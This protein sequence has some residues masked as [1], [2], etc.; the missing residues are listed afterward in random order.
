[1]E[2]PVLPIVGYS[3]PTALHGVGIVLLY[4]AKGKL[5]NQKMITLN[6]A[7]AEL[8]YCLSRAIIYTLYMAEKLTT[9]PFSILTCFSYIFFLAIRFAILHIIIDRFLDIWLN[10]Q[11]ERYMNK[12]TLI[13]AIIIQWIVGFL[14]AAAV[15]ILY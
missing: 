4:K 11:Y 14:V 10:L 1:M 2:S 6:L 5:L 13:K 3:L 9:L 8:L 12:N 15:I 7:V